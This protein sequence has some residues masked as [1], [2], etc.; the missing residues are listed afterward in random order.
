MNPDMENSMNSAG[1]PESEFS[2]ECFQMYTAS[3]IFAQGLAG[4]VN[5][6]KYIRP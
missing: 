1:K 2:I 6:I 4:V 5:I 3:E